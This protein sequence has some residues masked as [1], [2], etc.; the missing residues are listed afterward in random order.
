MIYFIVNR[1]QVPRLKEL[2]REMDKSA[3]ISISEVADV[4]SANTDK[5]KKGTDSK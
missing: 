3:Y 4:F 2:V 1:F 5:G